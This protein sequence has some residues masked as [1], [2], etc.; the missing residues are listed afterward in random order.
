MEPGGSIR[1]FVSRAK[2]PGDKVNRLNRF[3]F[4]ACLLCDELVATHVRNNQC[5]TRAR[6]N[7][8]SVSVPQFVTSTSLPVAAGLSR[9]SLSDFRMRWR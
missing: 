8:P 1:A 9:A 5:I 7:Q 6:I 2:R 4:S 3:L